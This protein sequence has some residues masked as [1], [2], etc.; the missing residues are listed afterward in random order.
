MGSIHIHKVPYHLLKDPWRQAWQVRNHQG[1]VRAFISSIRYGPIHEQHARWRL[2]G[3]HFAMTK[4]SV[5][6]S[7]EDKSKR[8][9]RVL[10]VC[11]DDDPIVIKNETFEDACHALGSDNVELRSCNA[12]HEL[13]MTHSGD[14]VRM[15]T[16]FLQQE[17]EP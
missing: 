11:G 15:I 14:I 9:A 10:V 3:D 13:P 5:Q 6:D 2:V 4:S 8:A 16:D 1:F 12:G 17:Q 7:Q